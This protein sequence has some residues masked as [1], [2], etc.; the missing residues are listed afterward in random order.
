[1]AVSYQHTEHAWPR[2]TAER[3]GS[4]DHILAL[5]QTPVA[6]CLSQTWCGPPRIAIQSC[7]ARGGTCRKQ[8]QNAWT[9]KRIGDA[10]NGLGNACGISTVETQTRLKHIYTFVVNN[11]IED[12]VPYTSRFMTASHLLCA[13][14]QGLREIEHA[15]WHN[16]VYTLGDKMQAV[17]LLLKVAYMAPGVPSDLGQG[18]LVGMLWH[19]TTV[20]SGRLPSLG[21][22]SMAASS[23]LSEVVMALMTGSLGS[24]PWCA[25]HNP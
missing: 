1:M 7:Q 5:A 11:F 6:A 4:A 9:N 8:E 20:P 16:L 13:C 25:S 18:Q 24:S 3:S 21:I 10:D 22:F 17:S 12:L 23:S 15:V 14:R 2:G 19:T